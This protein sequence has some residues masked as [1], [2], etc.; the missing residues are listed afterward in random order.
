MTFYCNFSTSLTGNV[1]DR[2]RVGK[3]LIDLVHIILLFSKDHLA[4]HLGKKDELA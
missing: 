3:G 2:K 4:N 1:E